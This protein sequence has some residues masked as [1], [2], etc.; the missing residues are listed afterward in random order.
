[1]ISLAVW[2]AQRKKAPLVPAQIFRDSNW[3]HFNKRSWQ[4]WFLQPNMA[5]RNEPFDAII[6]CCRWLL[7]C[8]AVEKDWTGLEPPL[9]AII[10]QSP[11]QP[12]QKTSNKIKKNEMKDEQVG[13][14]ILL[15]V[16]H[17]KNRTLI[18]R[19]WLIYPNTVVDWQIN[20]D[21]NWIVLLREC[22]V[23]CMLM[24]QQFKERY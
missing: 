5:F 19:P 22:V 13:I 4:T 10:T 9:L 18:V 6:C 7:T 17:K 2:T 14:W 24:F 23:T 12:W 15:K 11:W 20:V 8:L 16:L 21:I 1:M 3:E